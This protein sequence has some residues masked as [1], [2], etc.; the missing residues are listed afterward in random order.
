MK[1]IIYQSYQIVSICKVCVH[2]SGLEFV[3][4]IILAHDKSQFKRNNKINKNIQFYK[5]YKIFNINK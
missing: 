3:Y 4:K 1:F 5:N 2:S